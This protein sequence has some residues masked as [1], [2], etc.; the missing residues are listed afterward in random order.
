MLYVP[1]RT[2]QATGQKSR[3]SLTIPHPHPQPKF[4]LRKNYFRDTTAVI[5]KLKDKDKEITAQKS[6]PMATAFPNW[7]F[8][9]HSRLSKTCQRNAAEGGEIIT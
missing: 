9:A 7:E 8:P 2:L 6:L 3:W 4:L 5:I 1:A